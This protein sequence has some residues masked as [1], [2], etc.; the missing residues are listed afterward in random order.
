MAAVRS[1]I[2]IPP[3]LAEW[4]ALAGY[5]LTPETDDGRAMFWSAGGEVRYF[6]GAGDNG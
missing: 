2:V 1:P 4:A 5:S 3:Q 6:I